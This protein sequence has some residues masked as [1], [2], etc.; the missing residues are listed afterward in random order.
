MSKRTFSIVDVAERA[1]VSLATASR[2]MSN[3]SY[4]VNA[5]TR[6]K[7]LAAA[8]ELGYSPNSLARSLRSQRSKLIAVLVG[9]NVDPYFAEITRG[10]EEVANEQGYLTIIC[11]TDRNPTKEL[12]YLR[13]LRDY[14]ADGLIFA[15][16]GLNNPEHTEQIEKVVMDMQGRGAAAIALSQHTLH[17]PSIQIDNFG[18]GHAITAMLLEIGHRRIALIAGPAGL[19][20]ANRRMQGYMAALVEK[21]IPIDPHLILLGNFDQASGERAAQTIAQMELAQR[22]TAIF[23]ANDEMAFGVMLALQQQGIRVPQDI[24]V[25]GFGDIPMSRLIAPALTTVHVPLRQLGRSGA[26]R[27]L[28]ILRQEEVPSSEILPITIV[29]RASATSPLTSEQIEAKRTQ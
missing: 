18:G 22:P 14:R 1:G 10:V 6:Q 25:C 24:S 2:V 27:L 26:E 23:A 16:S 5:A 3:S 15:G 11:N 21:G 9:D 19:T 28:A 20:A 17:V 7:V 13:T 4:P 8:A 29:K 12:H